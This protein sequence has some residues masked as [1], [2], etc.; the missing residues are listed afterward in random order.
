LKCWSLSGLGTKSQ[1]KKRTGT[2]PKL[3]MHGWSAQK[4]KKKQKPRDKKSQGKMRKNTSKRRRS[5]ASLSNESG[6]GV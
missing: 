4:V 5:G 3:N 1:R 6:R 2:L